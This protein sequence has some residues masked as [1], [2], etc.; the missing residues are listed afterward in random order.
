MGMPRFVAS[1]QHVRSG[2]SYRFMVMDRF[3]TDLQKLFETNGKQFPEKT[4]FTLA[5][6]VVINFVMLI[7]NYTLSVYNYTVYIFK[8]LM[9]S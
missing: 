9:R 8:L 2:E 4:V 1:G 5:I 7:K 6:Q 3:N